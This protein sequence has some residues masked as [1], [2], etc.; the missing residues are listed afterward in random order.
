[1]RISQK[2]IFTALAAMLFT[3]QAHAVLFWARPYNPN[4]QRWLT[5]D[6]IGEQG[7]INLY[8]YVNNNPVNQVDPLGLWSPGAHDCMLEHAFNGEISESDINILK[9]SS[10]DFDKAHQGSDDSY[11]HSMREKGQ[12]TEDAIKLRNDFVA[13]RLKQARD[14]NKS[15]DRNKALK[16]LGEAMHPIMDI[17][18]PMHTDNNG[19]PKIWNPLWPFGH[20][21]NDSIGDETIHDLTPSILDRDDKAMHILYKYVFDK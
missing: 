11:M 9:K 12:K 13:D 16:L 2:I 20:S 5:R 18:S 10:R 15:G 21:P 3:S 14:A 8:G 4:L 19:N 6:P 17:S 1:M 7:G